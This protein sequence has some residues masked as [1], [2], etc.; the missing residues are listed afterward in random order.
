MDIVTPSRQVLTF[1]LPSSFPARAKSKVDLPQ[2]GGP[3]SKVIL[4]CGTNRFAWSV[5]TKYMKIINFKNIIKMC[6]TE[7]DIRLKSTS[8]I[9]HNNCSYIIVLS[10]SCKIFFL[11]RWKPTDMMTVTH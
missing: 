11:I 9:I 5:Q 2:P 7:R 6:P 4:Q 10:L 8:N 1:K 3:K